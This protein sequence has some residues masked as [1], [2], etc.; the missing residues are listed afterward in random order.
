MVAKS[1]PRPCCPGWQLPWQ[2]VCV[3]L[4]LSFPLH[5]RKCPIAG[6]PGGAASLFLALPL[7]FCVFWLNHSVW[8]WFPE[9][10]ASAP[11]SLSPLALA[12]ALP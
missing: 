7:I 4:F 2:E 11:V 5:P 8:R 3:T 12:F 1:C 6:R 10:A 9:P